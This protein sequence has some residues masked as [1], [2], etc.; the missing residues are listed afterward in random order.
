MLVTTYPWTDSRGQTEW[1]WVMFTC[2]LQI[3]WHTWLNKH[4]VHHTTSTF[5][6]CTPELCICTSLL[7]PCNTQTMLHHLLIGQKQWTDQHDQTLRGSAVHRACRGHVLVS[8]DSSIQWNVKPSENQVHKQSAVLG[9]LSVCYVK[10]L[11]E[12]IA[13]D[14]LFYVHAIVYTL[15]NIYFW[16]IW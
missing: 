6:P 7:A 13:L 10:Q 9:T 4:L 16:L 14:G 2:V 11:A 15:P 5:T 3:R 12:A 8:V 1:E